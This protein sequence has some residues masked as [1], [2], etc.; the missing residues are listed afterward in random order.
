MLGDL[1][2]LQADVLR[3]RTEL[4]ANL[5]GQQIFEAVAPRGNGHQPVVLLPGFLVSGGSLGRLK[6]FLN[7]NGFDA[8]SWGAGRNLGPRG[9]DMEAHLLHLQKQIGE[10]VRQLADRHSAPVALVG[11]SLGGVYARE[12]ATRLAP[13]IDRVIM[14]GSPAFHP[15]LK[16]RH[17]SVVGLLGYGVA[18]Q[19]TTRFAGRWGLLHWHSEQPELPC[20]S[21][22]SPIDGVVDEASA[23]IPAYVVERS[24]ARAPRENIRVTSSHIGMGVNPWVLLAVAD[25]L[26]Q[27][28]E[29]WRSFDPYPYFP[30]FL[31]WAVAR[32]YPARR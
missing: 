32:A 14:L 30:V 5:L 7:S 16:N 1:W 27:T 4:A 17:N 24:T 28:R 6:K 21:I 15:Y 29:E 18:R 11:Q 9:Q 26:A 20:V 22:C 23:S 19:T 12:L 25:R 2:R 13:E 8:H 3:A 10:K 31:H